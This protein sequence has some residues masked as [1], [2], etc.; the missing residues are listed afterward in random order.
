MVPF[1]SLPFTHRMIRV[2][3]QPSVSVDCRTD[4]IFAADRVTREVCHMQIILDLP[5]PRRMYPQLLGYLLQVK[6][7]DCSRK[8]QQAFP[9]RA[10]N[11]LQQR[12]ATSPEPCCRQ[13][14]RITRTRFKAD[15]T[16]CAFVVGDSRNRSLLLM[17]LDL[18]AD[19]FAK[20]GD[21][22]H[23]LDVRPIVTPR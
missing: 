22:R 12:I 10:R 20:G 3:S 6:G 4:F 16:G 2:L 14:G 13:G 5:D 1:S 21:H 11:A 15:R 18:L 8:R 9:E 17:F 19:S 7:W 23:N